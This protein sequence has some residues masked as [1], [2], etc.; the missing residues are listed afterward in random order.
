MPRCRPP[1]GKK[2]EHSATDESDTDTRHATADGPAALRRAGPPSS[3]A[4]CGAV[5]C[6]MARMRAGHGA[7]PA[8]SDVGDQ[9]TY[10]RVRPPRTG[11]SLV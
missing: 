6:G 8:L 11:F 7:S 9:P 3:Y 4:R 10:V 1:N 5:A 2:R